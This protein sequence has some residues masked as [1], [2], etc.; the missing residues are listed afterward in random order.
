MLEGE[1]HFLVD[2]YTIGL[3]NADHKGGFNLG[4]R[5]SDTA[6]PFWGVLIAG[7]LD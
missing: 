4:I 3:F 6:S 1:R 2:P 7:F 5:P